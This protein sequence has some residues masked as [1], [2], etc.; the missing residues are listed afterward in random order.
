MTQDQAFTILTTGAHVFLTGEPGSGKTHT[1]SRYIAWLRSRGIPV[2]IT[3]S[4]GIAATHIGG[5]TV[6]SFAGIGVKEALT[7]Q[8]LSRIAKNSR[9]AKRIRIA[10]VL[11]I[12]E[13]SMLSGRVLGMVDHVCRVL[14]DSN[15][16]FGGMQTVLV[17]DF[18]Q[19]PPVVKHYNELSEHDT[20]FSA[21]IDDRFCFNAPVWSRLSPSVCYLSEQYRQQD[22]AF[23]EILSA[24]R[25]GS[26]TDQHRALL[27]T[28][29]HGVPEQGVTHLFSH[30]AQVDRINDENLARLSDRVC[31]FE[32]RGSGPRDLVEQLKRGCLSPEILSLKIGARVMFTKN[33]SAG[34]FV[35]GTLGVVEGFSSIGIKDAFEEENVS[36]FPIVR[37]RNGKTICAEPLEWTIEG[38][39]GPRARISQIPL[40]LAWALTV[41]KSQG[42]SLDAA[43][44]DLSRVFEFGQ[45]YVALSR[46]RS[47]SGLFLSGINDHA[48]EVHPDIIRKDSEF[49]THSQRELKQLIACPDEELKNKVEMFV[50][51]CGGREQGA[52]STQIAPTRSEVKGESASS[53]TYSVEA[54]RIHH[55]NAYQSWSEEEEQ[56]LLDLVYAG[57]KIKDIAEKLGRQRG[58]ISSRLKKI[59]EREEDSENELFTGSM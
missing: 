5:R 49:R 11:I 44:M 32:M 50:R 28:R 13:V 57:E 10:K 41:H 53:R 20:L 3:A 25:R 26:V 59:R 45:G 42:M 34:R 38:E 47:L 51:Q 16:S 6:H 8:D 7:K 14:R 4:T 23:L 37:C 35:N 39:G 19:L 21:T 55:A 48:F 27:A 31:T 1:V 40:R 18:F 17:G 9:T 29:Q 12:D 24:L 22:N 43:S 30:N 36:T 58:A 2:A 52:P 15:E 54:L 56:T 33:D 46:V